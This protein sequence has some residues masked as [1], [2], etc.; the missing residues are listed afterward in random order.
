MHGPLDYVTSRQLTSEPTHSTQTASVCS[1]DGYN[2]IIPGYTQSWLVHNVFMASLLLPAHLKVKY[3][4]LY[5]RFQLVG[6]VS[7]RWNK[8]LRF[9]SISLRLISKFCSQFAML[10]ML[11]C[12]LNTDMCNQG[13]NEV[14]KVTIYLS[15]LT[16]KNVK[17]TR[18]INDNV[19]KNVIVSIFDNV[20]VAVQNLVAPNE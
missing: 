5:S 12:A 1:C 11:S 4:T 13:V 19:D 20:R 18:L 10:V 2:I 14:D 9:E 7:L 3:W 6:R 15:I 16:V 17:K 8:Y